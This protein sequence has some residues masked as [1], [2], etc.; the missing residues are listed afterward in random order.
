MEGDSESGVPAELLFSISIR[1]ETL[2][3]FLCPSFYRIQLLFYCMFKYFPRLY[4]AYFLINLSQFTVRNI[5][6][7]LNR[8]FVKGFILIRFIKLKSS[9]CVQCLS[10]AAMAARA[11]QTKKS[12]VL[13]WNHCLI[14]KRNAEAMTTWQQIIFEIIS[15]W[16]TAMISFK[17]VIVHLLGHD[18]E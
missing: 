8:T 14:D 9:P 1:T 5:S 17:F 10:R 2:C 6:D 13:P 18:L 4:Q 15:P 12:D 3:L 16:I 7:S 11:E